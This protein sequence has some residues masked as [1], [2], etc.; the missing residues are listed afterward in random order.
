MSKPYIAGGWP[1]IVIQPDSEFWGMTAEE[2]I[3]SIESLRRKA[4]DI[5]Y[6]G[7]DDEKCH[8]CGGFAN[9][10][11]HVIARHIGGDNTKENLVPCCRNCNSQKGIKTIEEYRAYLGAG[12]V[13][14]F[15]RNRL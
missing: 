4:I 7:R 5:L 6:N 2:K 13:F 12:H 15:E 9:T 11:D 8:Y 1:E 14:Y 3:A 10:V